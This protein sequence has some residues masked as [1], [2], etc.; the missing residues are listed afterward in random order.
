LWTFGDGN[1]ST[2]KNP[3]HVYATAAGSPFNVKL[4]VSYDGACPSELTK[5]VTITAA[6]TMNISNPSNTFTFCPGES[7]TLEVLGSFNNYLWNTGATT[8]SIEVTTAGTYS[9]E[10]NNSG[11]VLFD[12]QEVTSFPAPVV[13]VLADPQQIIA[14]ATSQLLATGLNT[15]SWTP[16]ESLSDPSIANPV[17]SPLAT[18]LYTVSGV[19]NNGCTGEGTITVSVKGEAVV[20]KLNP[21]NF[22][23]PNG[24]ASNPFWVIGE[25]ENYPQC[26]VTIYDDKGVKV[27]EA[28]PYLNNWD[29]TFNGNGK[30]LP[31]GVY[32]YIIRCAGEE[33][34]P[35][36]GSI[37]LLR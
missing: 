10:V 4:V 18:T 26:G 23:S 5:Q 16:P 30:Q 9:V 33:D 3:Q 1:S 29:G 37:T 7:L 35:R 8:S 31:D 32:Y 13:S 19:D 2:D 27:F 12:D 11:C 20:N 17:A 21:G 6:P 36:S 14:G 22:F 34:N 24:D 25:I 15:Y 28:S